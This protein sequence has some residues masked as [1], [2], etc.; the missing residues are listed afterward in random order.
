MGKEVEEDVEEDRES[1]ASARSNRRGGKSS[2][3]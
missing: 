1:L 3:L 2:T